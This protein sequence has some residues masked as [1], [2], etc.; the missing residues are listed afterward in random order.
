M[1]VRTGFARATRWVVVPAMI[2]ALLA[3]AAPHAL[4]DSQTDLNKAM[5][6]QRNVQQQRQQTESELSQVELDAQTAQEQLLAVESDLATANSELAVI[7]N[8]LTGAQK[9]VAKVESDLKTATDQFNRRKDTLA[10]RVRAINEEGRVNYLGVLLGSASFSDFISRFDLLKSVVKQDST[11]FTQVRDEKK[12]LEQK[13]LD[14]QSR[15][16]Q[17]AALQAQAQ[18]HKSVVEAKRSER[19]SVSRTLDTR[20]REIQAQLDDLDQKAQAAAD[21]IWQL[22]Q[23]SNRPSNGA[24]NPVY[25]V[26]PV[27]ITDVFGPRLHP[28]LNVWRPHNGTD[29]AAD[30]GQAVY[31]ITDGE[32][33][34]AG[35]SDAGYGNLVVIDHGGGYASWYGHA[36]QIL[37]SVGQKVKAGQQITRA[38]ST[39]WAT[40][41]HLH[42]EIHVN[43]KPV[44]PMTFF[45]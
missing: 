39:G 12:A 43:G 32:V 34:V 9:E 27:T 40:G 5:E 45:N 18:S 13:E 23:R 36:S 21:A 11:L 38:G 1:R 17:L 31:A 22:Q 24:F 19:Q 3:Q 15:R 44:D 37:V 6:Q 25:P 20:K 30:T 41:P 8:Q 14:A 16:N 33:I 7:N 28:I 2:G 35:W 42:L 29:F 26:R 4:A 10:R